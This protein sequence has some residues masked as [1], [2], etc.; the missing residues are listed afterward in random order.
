MKLHV[1]S[2]AKIVNADLD[3]NGI[4]IVTGLNNTGKT[5]IGKILFAMFNSLAHL[6][7]RVEEMRKSNL[8]RPLLSL[9]KDRGFIPYAKV[10]DEIY[11]KLKDR[12]QLTK[13]S[14]RM[15][16]S[17]FT[18][19]QLSDDEVAPLVDRINECNAVDDATLRRQMVQNWLLRIFA[20]QIVPL[21]NVNGPTS[22]TL[23]LKG[24]D[25]TIGVGAD[26]PTL[27]LGEPIKHR[28]FFIDSPDI[29]DD[30]AFSPAYGMSR[31]NVLGNVLVRAIANGV[32]VTDDPSESAMADYL[33]SRKLKRIME[34]LQEVL[35]GHMV[36]DPKKGTVFRDDNLGDIQLGNMSE[37]LKAFA[38]LQAAI[39]RRAMDDYDVLILDEPE[40][41]LHPAWELAYAELVVLL[42]QEF[43]LTILL[44]THSP[45]FMS[46]VQSFAKL[47]G[48]AE[49]EVNA[50][51]AEIDPND[52]LARIRPMSSDN[53]DE[54][55]L[56]FLEPSYRLQDLRERAAGEF[57]GDED[58]EADRD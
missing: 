44:T 57:E 43:H 45:S 6:D 21:K 34:K 51:R 24:K 46:A 32:K 10:A 50:Y 3:F 52:G 48:L 22:F 41:H 12:H 26:L 36:F 9:L 53:W 13:E 8:M 55:Y 40:V 14:L 4:T 7:E 47:N 23:T 16:L 27:T 28:A 1:Q 5:T 2:F 30:L 42:R 49:G 17:E 38:L 31:A 37:G 33:S 20:D 29:L 25:T 58:D 35:K 54:A 18:N 11:A 39:G 15:V 19:R 56:G